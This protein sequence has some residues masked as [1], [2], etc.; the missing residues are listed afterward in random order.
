MRTLTA[1]LLEE[2]KKATRRPLVKLAVASYGHPAAVASASLSWDDYTWVRLTSPTDATTLGV[3]HAV[4]IPS[5]GSVCRVVAKSSKVYFQRVTTPSPAD[6][7]EAT[8]TNLGTI[9]ATTKVA[10]AAMGTEVVVFADD[11]VNLYRIQSADCGASW[12]SWVSMANARPGERGISSAYKSNGDLAVVHASDFNDPTSLYIQ[13]RTGGTWSGGLGQIAGDFELIALTLYHQGD[14]NILGLI[15]DGSAITLVRGIYGDGGSFPAGTWSGW[16]YVNSYK[17]T[18]SFTGQARLRLWK[19]QGR[20]TSEPTYYER[21]S[22]VSD[23]QVSEDTLGVNSP[24]ITYHSSL[25]AVFSFAKST[26]PWFY[27]LRTGSAFVAMD[28]TKVWPIATTAM[29]GLAL[30]CDGT[31]LYASAP[32]QV[33]RCSLSGNWTPPTPGAG[34]GTNYLLPTAH[35]L[36]VKEKVEALAPGTLNLTLDNSTGIYNTLGTGA[37]SAIGQLALGAQVTLSIGYRTSSDLFSVAGKYY[38]E[39][40]GY[41]RSPGKSHVL[42]NCVDAWFLLRRY[43]FHCPMS[44]NSASD[45]T[46]IYEI[47]GLIVQAIGGTLSYKSRSADITGYYPRL[48]ISTGENG[49]IVL[50]QLLEMVPDVIYF[51]G[52]TGYIV[53]PQALDAASYELRFPI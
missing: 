46:C 12:G 43:A 34:P 13:M 35:V 22:T 25:G 51:D 31:Y 40:I 20:K 45:A 7:W 29:Q 14:W 50:R 42:I 48:T 11:G 39:S 1:D 37:A 9:T 3:N 47:I 21:I 33:W 53:Y 6:N 23:M 24:F 41:S 52:L 26:Q 49:A 32:N 8:W 5:D 28:C 27:R 10:I 4:A 16:E 30:A 36:G 17:T 2:Q 19:T 15:L 18:I 38:V 44:W